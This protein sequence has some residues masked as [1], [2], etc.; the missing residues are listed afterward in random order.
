M[1]LR[2]LVGDV[3]ASFRRNELGSYASAIAFRVVLAIVPFL[4]FV[5]GLLGFLHLEEVWRKDVAPDVADSTSKTAFRLIDATVRR[6]L[7]EKQ[8]WWV[9]IGLALVIWEL[10]SATRITMRTLDTVYGLRRRRGFLELLPRSLLLGTAMGICVVAALTV[11]RFGP[12]LTGK[13]HGA[14]AALSFLARWLLAAATLGLGI[15][16]LV[17]YGAGTRQP[18]P[19]VSFGTGVVLACWIGMS[20]VFGLYVTYIAS[21]GSVFG[22]LATFFVLFLY[23]YA[24]AIAFVIGVQVDACVRSEA[25]EE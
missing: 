2:E 14:L 9:T 18:F 22:H 20:I 15:G 12:L 11:V 19:W 5:L 7:T 16:L 25:G 13:V 8:A 6:V 3:I 17:R 10:S 1:P 21:Y 23:V 24:S 4:L